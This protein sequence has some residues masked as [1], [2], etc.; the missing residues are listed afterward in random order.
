[1]TISIRKRLFATVSLLIVFFVV[2]SWLMNSAYLEK[3]YIFQ[4]RQNL[5]RVSQDINQ[6]YRGGIE[7]LAPQIENLEQI[8]GLN[9]LILN[10]NLEVKYYSAL[11]PNDQLNRPRVRRSDVMVPLVR[12]Y[13]QNLQTGRR[14][15]FTTQD[16]GQLNVL[17][18]LNNGDYLLLSRP[19]VSLQE[20]ARVA[21]R[22]FLLT[23]FLT[24]LLGSVVTYLFSRRFTRPIL[25]IN[26][27]AQKMSR[28]DFSEKYKI[29]S[30]DEIGQLGE[31]INSLSDQLHQSISELQAANQKLMVDIERERQID[32]MRKQ[33][34]S[35][36]SHELKTPIALIQGY[37]EGL[38]DN[39]AED[40]ESKNFYCDVIA[41]EALKM[42]KIVRELLDL[43]QIEAGFFHIETNTFDINQ[44]VRRVLEKYELPFKERHIKLTANIEGENLVLG[45]QMRIE[46]V[47]GN[48]LDNALNHVDSHGRVEVGMEVNPDLIRVSVFNSGANI[49][50]DDL[51]QIFSSFYKIDQA[52]TRS[53]GGSGLGLSIVR[54]IM[55]RHNNG[56]GA[57]N[58]SDGVEFW[59]ELNR[60][61]A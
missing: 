21:N 24:I 43:S 19:L 30:H 54:A 32:L 47:L 48:Y 8:P 53:Y 9:I 60:T 40:E 11:F 3:F 2:L 29:D 39:V 27:I 31:S 4:I 20:G 22:F 23:G 52:R 35:N 13:L 55:E 6:Q 14:V 42:D 56:Y 16:P 15:V 1:M 45:D 5:I 41:D 50:E 49:L 12:A 33:F 59:F 61:Q 46:Q 34:I 17:S 36:V 58:L 28:L 10:R 57:I 51:N 44:T 37:A 38:K 26:N 7:D 25:Q 18:Q